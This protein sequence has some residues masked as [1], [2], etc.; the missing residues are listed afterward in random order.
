MGRLEKKYSVYERGTDRPIVIYGTARECAEAM[1]IAYES[2][3]KFLYL[4]KHR[5]PMEKY[6]IFEDPTDE[7]DFEE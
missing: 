3:R 6:E 1:G 7:E 4:Q 2:F 5:H